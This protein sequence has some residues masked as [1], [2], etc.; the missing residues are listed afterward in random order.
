MKYVAVGKLNCISRVIFCHV[1]IL[2]RPGK[3]SRNKWLCLSRFLLRK[4]N[5][6]CFHV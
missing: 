2:A 1:T 3:V 5:T 4:E 6:V